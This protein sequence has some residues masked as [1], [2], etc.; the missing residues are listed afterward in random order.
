MQF[1]QKT[2]KNVVGNLE[3]KK[4]I[5]FFFLIRTVNQSLSDRLFPGNTCH[6][7]AIQTM[8]NFQ[9]LYTDFIKTVKTT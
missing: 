8:L 3:K 7:A 6:H 4:K 5:F 9:A 1:A 2:I